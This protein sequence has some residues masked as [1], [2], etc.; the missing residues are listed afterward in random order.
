VRRHYETVNFV[1]GKKTKERER[2]KRKKRGG[3]G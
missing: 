3:V 2:K 1:K